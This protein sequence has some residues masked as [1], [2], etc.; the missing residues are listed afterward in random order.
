MIVRKN[1]PTLPYYWQLCVR[2]KKSHSVFYDSIWWWKFLWKPYFIGN[3]CSYFYCEYILHL[4]KY[5]WIYWN[6]LCSIGIWQIS[7]FNFWMLNRFCSSRQSISKISF[8]CFNLLSDSYKCHCEFSLSEI[9]NFSVVF[10]LYIY[11]VSSKSKMMRIA[12]S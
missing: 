8:H 10:W 1:G 11:I 2:K 3:L 5:F 4:V 6:I 12:T 7:L 9:L